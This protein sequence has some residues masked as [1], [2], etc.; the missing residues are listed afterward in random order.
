MGV[1]R[2]PGE[3]GLRGTARGRY[4]KRLG[5]LGDVAQGGLESIAW[6]VARERS[7]DAPRGAAGTPQHVDGNTF[8]SKMAQA[9]RLRLRC[10]ES[11]LF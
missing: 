4:R 6:S 11:S 7:G 1:I 9:V 10:G 3:V 8:L 5:G 2:M